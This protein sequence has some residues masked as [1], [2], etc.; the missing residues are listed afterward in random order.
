MKTTTDTIKRARKALETEIFTTAIYQYL[1][2]YADKS[3]HGAFSEILAMEKE[4]IAFWSEFLEKRGID[5]RR[6]R[7]SVL[8]LQLYKAML[9][10]LG[11]GLTLR[12][13]ETSESQAIELYSSIQEDP[14]LTEREKQELN[15]V[16]GDELLHEDI[17]INEETK[18]AGFTIYIKDAVLG[19]SD[20]L[21]EILA[22]T[23]G[24]AG[25]AGIPMV[26]A[27]SGLVVSIAGALSMGISTY[28]STR[29]QRQVHEGIIN[30]IV[31]ASRFVG[32]IFKER[33]VNHLTRQGYS[34][35]LARDM[36]EESAS[37]HRLLSNF[38]AEQEYGIRKENLGNPSRAALY[39]GLSNLIGSL[40]PLLP[41]FFVSNIFTALILS[42]I[43]ATISLAVTGFFVSILAYL[44]PGK[45]IAEMILTGLGC[46]AITYG[47]GKAASSFLGTHSK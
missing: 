1:A 12:I 34:H 23:T 19:M 17:F 4:H 42:L 26:V 22:V 39:A 21:V 45:K 14:S 29:S 44:T 37:D 9:R 18:F 3:L 10:T 38:I 6:V 16:L 31:S 46:A 8:R 40:I 27:I 25:A 28:S 2:G 41:Y 20:G 36:A 47:I 35:R 11:K 7:P 15:K 30:R 33:V 43:L 5:T 32:H 24:L 13:M